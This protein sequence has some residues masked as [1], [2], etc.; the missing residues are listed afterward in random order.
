MPRCVPAEH[1]P[2]DPVESSRGPI[3]EATVA[4]KA[5]RAGKAVAGVKRQLEAQ[6]SQLEDQRA[7]WW[8]P[9]IHLWILTTT[10]QDPGARTACISIRSEICGPA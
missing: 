10:W 5:Q 9:S 2:Q 8:S 6:R 4:L 7:F 3:F 1:I